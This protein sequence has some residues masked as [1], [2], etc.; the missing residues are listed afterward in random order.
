MNSR[1]I[2]LQ[3]LEFEKPLRV[4][5]QI[6][7]L[8]WS[9]RFF[10][11][12]VAKIKACYPDDILVAPN[13]LKS[14]PRT[15]GE[16]FL[17]GT[18]TD[19]WGCE[20]CSLEDG[21]IGEVKNPLIKNWSDFNKIILPNEMLEVDIDKVN[22]FCIATDKF[23]YGP[24]C[25]RP[26][27]RLQFLRGTENVFMDFIDNPD[28]INNLLRFI[29]GF[30]LKEIEV[31]V[32]TRIDGIAFMDDWGS[33]R[34]LLVSPAKWRELFKPLY[35]EYIDIAHK[36]G[37]KAFMH[38]DGYI[39]DIIPD[40]ID[41]GL[42]ALNSQ[43]FCMGPENLTQ[44]R[45][46]L[47]FWG[48]IDRQH[49]LANGSTS[50]VADAVWKVANSLYQNGGCIAQCEFGPGAKPENVETVFKTWNSVVIEGNN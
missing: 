23:V 4:P 34:G 10:P 49:L 32:K 48:E 37:K 12:I 43:I 27:E 39:V 7:G 46:K 45:G 35:K 40:L 42:D 38:S 20:F 18:F 22:A 14:V 28:E 1:E 36:N 31:W 13:C 2:V 30:Y 11:D 6:W 16:Q 21:V 9:S 47:T 8:Q 17:K 24:C 41:I 3:T 29:H 33:Q 19:E 50:E 25:A 26:F 44:F 5:R 15:K